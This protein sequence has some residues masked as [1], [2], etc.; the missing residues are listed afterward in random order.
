MATVDIQAALQR[1]ES[2][3][4]RRPDK[5]LHT[6]TP[7]R[8]RWE[9]DLVVRSHHPGGSSVL[10]DMPPELG[11]GGR[12]VTPGW[13]MRAGLA[14]C[15]VTCVVFAAA[16]EGIELQSVEASA[17]SESDA[18]G[19]LG[20]REA[21]ATPVPSAPRALDLKVRVA[22]RGVSPARLERLVETARLRSAVL[23][24]LADGVQVRLSVQAEAS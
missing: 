19:I 18:R 12:E 15:T 14:A 6:D 23:C 9:H 20:M 22:A 17:E 7:A 13:L 10:T 5:G 21:D 3:L 4:T 11:G 8:A 1:V 24:A 16:A 2:V